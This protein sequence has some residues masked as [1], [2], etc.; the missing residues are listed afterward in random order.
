MT[1]LMNKII[2]NSLSHYVNEN[3]K[4]WSL[5]YKMIIFAYN[6]SPSSRLKQLQK[7]RDTIPEIV[8]KEQAVQK[9][10]YDISHKNINFKPGQKLL[11]K[12][13]FNEKDK[14][15]KL[16]NKYRGPFTIIEKISDLYELLRNDIVLIPK[17]YPCEINN[18]NTHSVKRVLPVSWT[19]IKSLNINHENKKESISFPNLTEIL[20]QNWINEIPNFHVTKQIRD[21]EKYFNGIMLKKIS[22]PLIDDF[23]G[24][25]IYISWLTMLTIII[26]F[27]G[28]KIYPATIKIDMLTVPPPIPQR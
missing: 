2:C 21:P 28:Y 3:Q 22:Q 20:N 8:E 11:I 5:Y 24:D 10:Q 6:T 16:A 25:I 1:E 13:D 4:Y 26:G 19:K 27:I 12:F 9:K 17:M 15:K 23:L 7:I 18:L 14:S